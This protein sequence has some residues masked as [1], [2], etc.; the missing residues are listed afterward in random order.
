MSDR[1]KHLNLGTKTEPVTTVNVWFLGQICINNSRTYT[2]ASAPA[3]TVLY[4]DIKVKVL[5]KD[6]YIS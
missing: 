1:N 3:V 2:V 5:Q 6:K 4:F